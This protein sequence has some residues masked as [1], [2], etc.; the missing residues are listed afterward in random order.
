MSEI[1]CKMNVVLEENAPLQPTFHDLFQSI[2]TKT[3]LL[4]LN[5][6]DELHFRKKKKPKITSFQML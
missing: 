6:G 3:E 5:F 2:E 4:T 1:R